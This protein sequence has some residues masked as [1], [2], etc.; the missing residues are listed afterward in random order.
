[1]DGSFAFLELN[2]N[3]DRA[4]ALLY[5]ERDLA[6][7]FRSNLPPK[8][9][10]GNNGECLVTS[11]VSGNGKFWLEIAEASGG[12]EVAKE[13]RGGGGV[14]EKPDS[15]LRLLLP[16]RCRFQE[17]ISVSYYG[18]NTPEPRLRSTGIGKNDEIGSVNLFSRVTLSLQSKLYPIVISGIVSEVLNSEH[19]SRQLPT[20]EEKETTHLDLE[21]KILASL[22]DNYSSALDY[23]R[24]QLEVICRKCNST[25]S[26]FSE[27]MIVAPLPSEM[28]IHASE[29][30]TCDNCS[31]LLVQSGPCSIDHD[32]SPRPNW[33]CLG[34]YHISLNDSNIISGSLLFKPEMGDLGSQEQTVDAFFVQDINNVYFYSQKNFEF[35]CCKCCGERLGWKNKQ[36]QHLNF[37][38]SSIL[39]GLNNEDKKRSSLFNNYSSTSLIA[40]YIQR[41]IKQYSRLC[42]AD[43]SNPNRFVSLYILKK[44]VTKLK[45]PI[46]LVDRDEDSSLNSFSS[47]ARPTVYSSIRFSFFTAETDSEAME[48]THIQEKTPRVFLGTH[49]FEQV[50]R[51]IEDNILFN[52]NSYL[53]VPILDCEVG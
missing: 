44:N 25:L 6:G 50:C 46:S 53:N 10:S 19:Q 31:P 38:K 43:L 48:H 49:Q 52:R 22:W 5:L 37:W 39:L 12:L 33:I 11:L 2:E 30:F 41:Y 23:D 13:M 47:T 42:I 4:A 34:Q 35:F 28:V 1:M 51:S 27:N 29:M 18:E 32:F 45:T 3:S 14:Q 40:F 21:A 24:T 15:R 7:I 26:C 20:I 36:D 9:D 17:I 8:V 16:G